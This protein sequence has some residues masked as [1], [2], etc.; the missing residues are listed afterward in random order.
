[1]EP[2]FVM[3]L[4]P[5]ILY[6]DER[7]YHVHSSMLGVSFPYP[8]IIVYKERQYIAHSTVSN[9]AGDFQKITYKSDDGYEFVVHN[10]TD[11]KGIRT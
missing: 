8:A 9:G 3:D 1:M 10:K 5:G 11:Q 7:C 2:I 6:G 4:Q